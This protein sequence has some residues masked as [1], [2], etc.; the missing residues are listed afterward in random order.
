VKWGVVLAC[1][2]EITAIT[3]GRAPTITM[4]CARH[5]LL[6]PVVLTVLAVHL[7]RQ[8][9]PAGIPPERR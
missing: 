4:L 9:R 2:Y 8:P 7:Y 6:A 5:R 3:T 1:G